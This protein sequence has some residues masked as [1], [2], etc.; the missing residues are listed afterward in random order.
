MGEGKQAADQY[1]SSHLNNNRLTVVII[2]QTLFID[3]IE[4]YYSG[5]DSRTYRNIIRFE[6]IVSCLIGRYVLLREI[7]AELVF[8]HFK[9][10]DRVP[11]RTQIV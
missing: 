4:G 11:C 6:H 8:C 3:N 9:C 7:W 10:G 2:D 1:R 5:I